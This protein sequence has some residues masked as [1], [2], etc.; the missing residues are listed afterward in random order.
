MRTAP[1]QERLDRNEAEKR[2]LEREL[3]VARTKL[4]TSESD[5]APVRN[6][7]EGRGAV[8]ETRGER[9]AQLAKW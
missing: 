7:V 3:K 4:A 2:A 1:T 5:G 6:E 9:R 8:G